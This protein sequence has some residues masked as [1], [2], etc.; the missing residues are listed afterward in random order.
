MGHQN[1][2][3]HLSQNLARDTTQYHFAYA[4]V[5]VSA[6]YRQIGAESGTAL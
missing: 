1:R 3:A 2:H 4:R 6:H 5:A